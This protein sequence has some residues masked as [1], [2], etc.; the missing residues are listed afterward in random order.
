MKFHWLVLSFCGF[1][2]GY[3]PA[4]AAKLLSWRFDTNQNQ[5]NIRTDSG[6]QPVVKV[7][8]NPTRL[9]IDLPGTVADL[10]DSSQMATQMVGG[11]VKTV[12]VGQFQA[13]IARLVIELAPGYTIDPAKVSVRGL[14]SQRWVINLP[15]PE[16]SNR[17]EIAQSV[18]ENQG[19]NSNSNSVPVTNPPKIES[20]DFHITENGLFVRFEERE[21]NKI[22]VNR[23]E[24][25][26][27][28]EI[29][30]TGVTLPPSLV[31]QKAAINQYGI[32]AIEFLQDSTSPSM[33]RLI[34]TVEEES[35][36]WLA[37]YSRLGNGGLVLIPKQRQVVAQTASQT[38]SRNITSNSQNTSNTKAI[39]ESIAL[40]ENNTKL[41]INATQKINVQTTRRVNGVYQIRLDNAE[42]AANF[43]RPQIIP[44]SPISRLRVWQESAE[45]VVVLVHPAI[46]VSIP[47]QIEQEGENSLVLRLEELTKVSR[48]LDDPSTPPRDSSSQTR[49][50]ERAWA[51]LERTNQ[52]QVVNKQERL[53]VV[54]DPGHGGKDPGAIG[55]NGVREKDVILPMSLKVASILEEQGIQVIMT[56]DRDHYVSLKNRSIMANERGADLFISIH[57]NSMGMSR[58]DVNGIETYYYRDGRNLAE[59]IHNSILRRVNVGN[60]GVR[61]ARFYVLRHTTMPAVLV[62][63]GFLTG[64]DD[65]K[66]LADPTYRQQVS[67][68]IAAGILQYVNSR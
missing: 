47:G 17:L 42:L 12:R 63:V 67:E 15:E 20:R 35:P 37:S 52:R 24:D 44:N 46:G 62:E 28:V 9:V 23:S 55:I 57:A 16:F 19:T 38:P 25:R 36:D 53:V 21:S 59:A 61:S 54:I 30:L 3:S 56:R 5:L 39:V 26:T 22:S 58:P 31:G 50:L 65:A 6:V 33:A 11:A 49:P 66:K 1:L 7:I 60:R 4:E 48:V 43:T 68:A 41:V 10:G 13:D 14:S 29:D 18:N 27:S 40:Q 32:K 8:H 64:R 45:T 51:R 34:L 2:L